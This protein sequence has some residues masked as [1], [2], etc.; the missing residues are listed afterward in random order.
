MTT[1]ERE[2]TAPVDLCAADGRLVPEARGWSRTPLHRANLRGRFGRNKRW[3][4]WAILAGDLAVSS[5]FSNVDY[6]G[7]V[8]VWWA[9]LATGRTGGRGA[10]VPF[11]RSIRL[12]DRPGTEPL[13]FGSKRL[14]VDM[15][16]DAGGT[17]LRAHWVERD[18]T[19]GRLDAYVALPAGHESLNVVIPWSDTTFQFT[20]KHQARPAR[21]EFAVGDERRV[22]GEDEPAWGVLDVGRGRWPYRTNW[23]WGGGAGRGSDGHVVGLQLG[24]KWTE[25]TG[26]TENGVIV[27]GRLSKIGDELTWQYSW[28]APLDPWHVRSPDGSLDLVLHPRYDKP[29]RI[30]IGVMGMQVHQVF[31]HWAGSVRTDDGLTVTFEDLPGFAEECRARW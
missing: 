5:T 2:I 7:I 1:A 26:A 8:D 17:R 14:T 21:G 28:D 15:T 29:T 12:P 3:D 16:D 4:Y 30:D 25:G 11:P 19:P 24:G 6:L 20:S 18:G 22:F 10:N 23:N 27:D 13:H 31:G 9:D